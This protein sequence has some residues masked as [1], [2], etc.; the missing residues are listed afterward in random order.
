MKWKQA[1]SDISPS[2]S[3]NYRPR[4]FLS[5][6]IVVFQRGK[7]FPQ[8]SYLVKVNTPRAVIQETKKA[9]RKLPN[10][11]QAITALSNLKGVGTTMASGL[12]TYCFWT[13]LSLVHIC[14]HNSQLSID[15]SPILSADC[16]GTNPTW[17]GTFCHPFTPATC[18][19][20]VYKCVVSLW[21]DKRRHFCSGFIPKFLQFFFANS[22][23][24][25][26]NFLNIRFRFLWI[27]PYIPRVRRTFFPSIVFHKFFKNTSKFS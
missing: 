14:T 27:N 24:L 15:K 25:L 22:W 7:F 6:T 18:R 19:D 3:I 8:L 9:F 12:Y 2:K 13:L 23:K 1:V 4:R 11:E 21:L 17:S 10:L 20:F 26:L 5:N 16:C